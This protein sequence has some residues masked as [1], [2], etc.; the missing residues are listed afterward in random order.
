MEQVRSQHLNEDQ[1]WVSVLVIT[2]FFVDK[3]LLDKNTDDG[4]LDDENHLSLEE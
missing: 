2:S 4:H 3:I 1:S